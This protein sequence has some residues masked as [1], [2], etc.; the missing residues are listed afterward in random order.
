MGAHANSMNP[1][2]PFVNGGISASLKTGQPQWINAHEALYRLRL[3]NI[4]SLSGGVLEAYRQFSC[5]SHEPP[6]PNRT[7]SVLIQ[8]QWY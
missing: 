2:I 1:A 7:L 5:G 3:S 8:Q 4:Y 6:Y